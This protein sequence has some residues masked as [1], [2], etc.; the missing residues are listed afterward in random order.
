MCE[1]FSEYILGKRVHLETDYK[2][3][4][5]LLSET[6]LDRLPPRVLRFRLRLISFDYSINHVPGKLLYTADALFHAPFDEVIT[7]ED[8]TEAMV[9]VTMSVPSELR[10]I[11]CHQIVGILHV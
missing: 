1:K 6:H 3:L 2:P 10:T 9:Y 5:P 8:D 7:D 11:V 4:V